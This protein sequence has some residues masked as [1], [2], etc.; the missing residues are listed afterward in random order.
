MERSAIRGR[1]FLDLRIRAI[2]REA[3]YAAPAAHGNVDG[4]RRSDTDPCFRHH[5]SVV[6]SGMMVAR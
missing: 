6:P 5:G 4:F 2:R 3:P 1:A